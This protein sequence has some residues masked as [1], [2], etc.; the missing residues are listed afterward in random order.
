MANK[1]WHELLEQKMSR[2]SFFKLGLATAG[3]A[4]LPLE[5]TLAAPAA[6]TSFAAIAPSTADDLLLPRGYRYQVVA[7][8]GDALGNNERFGFNNDYIGFFPIDGLEKGFDI[9]NPQGFYSRS[10][11]SAEV[12]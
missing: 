1:I 9:R 5:S 11:S 7:A 4:V 12:C 10:M 2:R 3:A 6:R 8:W